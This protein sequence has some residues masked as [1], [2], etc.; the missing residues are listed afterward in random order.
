MLYSIVNVSFYF[1]SSC[2]YIETFLR[3]KQ[4]ERQINQGF[5][6]IPQTMATVQLYNIK[7]N[8][9]VRFPPVETSSRFTILL[10]FVK[11][12]VPSFTHLKYFSAYAT[13]NPQQVLLFLM[14]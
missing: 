10:F 8:R 13:T 4:T 14:T 7:S 5:L 2:S 9:I 12:C 11:N 1:S 3:E 6:S